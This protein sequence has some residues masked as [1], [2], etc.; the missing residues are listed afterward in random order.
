MKVRIVIALVAALFSFMTARASADGDD[1]AGDGRQP[2]TMPIFITPLYDSNGPKISVGEYS[3]KL[4]STDAKAIIELSSELKKEKNKLR[5]EVMYV[6]AIRLYDLGQKDD[7]VYW[8]YT[9]QYRARLFKAILDKEKVGGIGSEAFEMK[10]AYTSFD[11]LAGKYINIYAFGDLAKLEETLAKVR[12][13][14]SSVPRFGELY[15]NVTFVE[16]QKWADENTTISKGLAG[17]IDYIK[18]NADSIKDQR[19]KN[20]VEGKD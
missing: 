4:E 16:E 20:G 12:E 2:T 5:P 18:T 1:K 13:E 15:P 6:A 7:A 10:Q 9:A 8:F 19:K 17:L 14:G 3:K 11:E